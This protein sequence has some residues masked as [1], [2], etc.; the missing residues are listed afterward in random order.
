MIK[1]FSQV[2]AFKK[3]IEEIKDPRKRELSG[4]NYTINQT[5]ERC[6]VHHY[7]KKIG[8]SRTRHVARLIC[9]KHFL[10]DK[11]FPISQAPQGFLIEERGRLFLVYDQRSGRKKLLN[12]AKDMIEALSSLHF[13]LVFGRRD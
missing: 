10:G 12:K 1:S 11:Y 6:T 5:G 13:F 8:E 2:A 9:V 7:G 4:Q 3:S